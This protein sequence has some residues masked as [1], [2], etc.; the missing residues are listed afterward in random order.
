M[1]K[2]I[3]P[4]CSCENNIKIEQIKLLIPQEYHLPSEYWV[5]EC[6]Q[7]GFCYADTEAS[8]EDYNNY[9][10]NCNT[11]SGTPVDVQEWDYL[12]E[13]V[14]E[15]I[16]NRIKCD[17]FV[18]DMGFG[19]GNFL[20][21]LQKN[22]YTN[23]IGI[24]PSETSVSKIRQNGICASVGSV[25]QSPSAELKNQ[26]KC[27][28]L[29]DVLE[30]LLFPKDAIQHIKEYLVEDGYLMLSVPNYA[31]LEKNNN[32]IINMFN[33]E[34]INYFSVISL[35]NIMAEFG[36]SKIASNNSSQEEEI[37][38]LYQLHNIA[39]R[40]LQ[41]DNICG[42]EIRDYV[43]RFDVRRTRIQD[44]L[45]SLK[46][47]GNSKIYV[48]GT[49]AFTMWLLANTILSE[50]E[51]SFI[52]NNKTKIGNTFWKSTIA[53]SES[54]TDKNQ[55]IVI[56]SMLYAKEIEKQIVNIGLSNPIIIL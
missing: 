15:L 46:L 1:S 34:H 36:F 53:G 45:Y 7:C 56:C 26:I 4:I 8:V 37:I 49:G 52:D 24:D 5:T 10:A 47:Q 33:Q 6:E 2:R 39:L 25:F 23:I 54:V 55:P 38:A 11:Y 14:G 18:L 32:P 20:K 27:V 35:D 3:C 42:D 29:F 19:Q 43:A 48:W 9:Y 28:F 17:D 41:R 16:K 40:D 51:I 30:H 44:K 13:T 21:W 22:G 12:H 50:F 31:F